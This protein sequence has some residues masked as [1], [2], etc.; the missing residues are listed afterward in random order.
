MSKSTEKQSQNPPKLSKK[1]EQKIRAAI[2]QLAQSDSKKAATLRAALRAAATE[3]ESAKGSA[4]V[5]EGLAYALKKA[6]SKIARGRAEWVKEALA[7]LRVCPNF[8][9]AA[10][11][12]GVAYGTIM[13]LRSHDAEFREQCDK[14][15][16]EGAETLEIFCWQRATQGVEKPIFGRNAK[17][18][19]VQVGVVREYSDRLAEVMLKAHLRDKYN[20]PQQTELSGPGGSAIPIVAPT[21]VQIII[22]DN[23]RSAAVT[24]SEI[25]QLS[26]SSDKSSD[27]AA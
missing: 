11:T 6:Q 3:K 15:M 10:K 5:G 17:G 14:A 20:P 2:K 25:K 9:Y 18:D 24:T 27:P 22:P 4:A 21:Q 13:Q 19:P 7:A 12:A 16:R 1:K 8:T 23:G 26:V